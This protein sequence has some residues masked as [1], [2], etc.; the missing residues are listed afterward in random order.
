[1]LPEALAAEFLKI[2]IGTLAAEK[3]SQLSSAH[4]EKILFLFCRETG[5]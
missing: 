1:L 2:K 4:G 3:S 5:K